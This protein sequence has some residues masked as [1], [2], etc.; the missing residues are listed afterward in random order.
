MDS[1]INDKTIKEL[2]KSIRY[3]SHI[4]K[5]RGREILDHYPITPPQFIALQWLLDS[6]DLTIGELSKKMY[7]AFSTTTDLV[8]RMENNELIER[9]RDP[10]DRRVVRIHLLQKGN[11]IIKEVIEKRQVYVQEVLESFSSEEIQSLHHLMS[12]MFNEMRVHEEK[13][14]QQDEGE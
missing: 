10:K 3:I 5:Q 6:G 2:E 12:R 13:S 9:V 1:T 14:K 8:D 11:E 4:I 7:F